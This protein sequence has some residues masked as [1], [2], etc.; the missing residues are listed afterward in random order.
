MIFFDAFLFFF[1]AF[2]VLILWF[3]FLGMPIVFVFMREVLGEKITGNV[4][5]GED[6]PL[7]VF[8]VVMVVP[9]TSSNA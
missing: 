1:G 9:P 6:F 2:Y 4:N 3:G 7:G 5:A 8:T